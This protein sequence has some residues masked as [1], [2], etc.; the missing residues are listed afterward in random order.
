MLLN[1]VFG[2]SD[3]HG[4]NI[5]FLKFENDI[6]FA[7]I[8]GF[9]PVKADPEMVTRLF[10][11]ERGCERAGVVKFDNVVTELEDF[12]EPEAL[13]TFLNELAGSLV[14]APYLL[15]QLGCP[16]ETLEFPSIGFNHIEEKLT[17]FGV[18]NA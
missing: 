9:A 5:S 1:L 14:Q 7:P 15:E 18:Y 16:R 8:Y 10:K 3:N 2:N 12:G 6:K 13:L 4:R 17:S 11:W